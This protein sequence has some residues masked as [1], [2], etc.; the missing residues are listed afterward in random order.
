MMRG[1]MTVTK[2]GRAISQIPTT[3]RIMPVIRRKPAYSVP[4]RWD[5]NTRILMTP[6]MVSTS[7]KA[8]HRRLA[9]GAGQIRSTSPNRV[10]SAADNSALA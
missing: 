8:M 5:K 9:E 1:M 2:V 10:Y 3:A 7:P 6:Q 4:S